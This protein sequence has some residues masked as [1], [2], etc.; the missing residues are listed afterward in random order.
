MTVDCQAKSVDIATIGGKAF[1]PAATYSFSIPSF[2]AAGGDG[3]PKIDTINAGL[4]DA[5]VLKDYIAAKRPFR[6]PIISRPARSAISTP[7]R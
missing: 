6:S 7:P 4:V 5:G 3:Y 2:S 1:D